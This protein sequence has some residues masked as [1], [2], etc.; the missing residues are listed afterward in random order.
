MLKISNAKTAA[1]IVAVLLM[2]S[3]M[4]MALPVSA[5]DEN[6]PHGGVTPE[7]GFVGPTTVPSDAPADTLYVLTHPYLAVST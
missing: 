3:V 2:T 6:A 1:I 7:N 4:F 5:Q